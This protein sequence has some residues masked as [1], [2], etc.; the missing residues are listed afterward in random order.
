MAL[1]G[2]PTEAVTPT[3]TGPR[4]PL[5]ISQKEW[6]TSDPSSQAKERALWPRSKRRWTAPAW[7]EL[8]A[9]PVTELFIVRMSAL[10]H[11]RNRALL[12][13]VR[14]WELE[15]FG[16][17]QTLVTHTYDW[18]ELA[19]EKRFARARATT[20]DKLE[21]SLGRLAAIAEAPDGQFA[22]APMP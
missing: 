8:A 4:E 16:S 10:T 14:A 19:D 15:P 1:E 13:P 6:W 9:G 5:Q 21:A 18:T 3:L 11:L 17:S 2:R 7:G 22:S 12:Q 20:A